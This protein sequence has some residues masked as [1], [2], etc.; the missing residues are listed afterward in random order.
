M[1]VDLAV[2]IKVYWKDGGY[3]EFDGNNIFAKDGAACI[4]QSSD[5]IAVI[6]LYNALFV[7]YCKD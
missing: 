4:Q 7:E 3:T 1:E 6:S 2:K 5:I